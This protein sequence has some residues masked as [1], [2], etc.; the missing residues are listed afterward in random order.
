MPLDKNVKEEREQLAHQMNRAWTLAE[1]RAAT[2]ALR[3][4]MEAHPKDLAIL[5]GGEMLS[6]AR[7]YAELR[8]AERKSLGFPEEIGRERERVFVQAERAHSLEEI[9]AA[10]T[11]ILRWCW[12]Y[13]C[14]EKIVDDLS[15]HLDS[16]EMIAQFIADSLAE[17]ELLI[18]ASGKDVFRVG[19][20]QPQTVTVS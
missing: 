6:H 17:S 9:V 15:R 20:N 16:R 7:D 13:P 1:V 12:N 11:Q 4:W 8:D 10:R 18:D 5:D 2:A 14:D 3:T 19:A